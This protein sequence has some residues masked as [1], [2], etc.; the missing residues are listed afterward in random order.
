MEDAERESDTEK[1]EDAIEDTKEHREDEHEKAKR[2]KRG[3]S[4]KH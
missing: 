3:I 1:K 4:K 2:R